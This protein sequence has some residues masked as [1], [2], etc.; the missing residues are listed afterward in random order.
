MDTPI[1]PT[2]D[3]DANDDAGRANEPDLITV[4]GTT[5]SPD[6]QIT[7]LAGAT[8]ARIPTG[9]HR[10]SGAMP[11]AS[12]GA[13]RGAL[14]LVALIAAIIVLVAIVGFAITRI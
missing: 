5:A 13:D 10:R 1:A 6:V 4:T 7:M 8:G 3:P 14:G 12:S 9:T 11:D 2:P